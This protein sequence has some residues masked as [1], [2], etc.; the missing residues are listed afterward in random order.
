[1]WNIQ[2]FKLQCRL[3]FYHGSFK[4]NFFV[5]NIEIILLHKHAI[6]QFSLYIYLLILV[7]WV[8]VSLHSPHCPRT[9]YVTQ[10]GHKLAIL[11]I[12]KINQCITMP[13]GRSVFFFIFDGTGVWTQG[14]ALT[15]TKQILFHMSNAS[16]PF[17]SGY[18][19]GGVSQTVCLGWPKTGILPI[20][21]SQLGSFVL[22]L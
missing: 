8:R 2:K 14:F 5:A 12:A 13:G 7:F 22:I 18:F 9:C 17:C 20:S 15:L 19:G 11:P 4:D 10:I 16:C 21:A 1:M 6:L 3:T